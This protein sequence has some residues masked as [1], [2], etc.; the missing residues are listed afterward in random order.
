MFARYS[1][2][3]PA[4]I[5]ER[6]LGEPAGTPIDTHHA[7]ARWVD[8]HP[9]AQVE[10]ATFVVTDDGVLR[11]A[12]RRSEHVGCAGG[13][14]VW[15]AGELVFARSSREALTVREA[16]NQSTGYAP[17]PSSFAALAHTLDALGIAR[18]SDWTAAYVFRRCPACAQLA[19]VKD[20]DFE[21]AVCGTTL[22]RERNL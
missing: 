15:T 12:P 19:L 22:P 2:I 7:A 4:S 13:A 14:A 9:E 5:R 1:Y 8:M 16:S 20:N 11:L 18:P 21:C 17:E 10:G 3:G 6:A